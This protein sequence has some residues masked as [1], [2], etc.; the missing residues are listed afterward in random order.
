SCHGVAPPSPGNQSITPLVGSMVMPAGAVSRVHSSAGPSTSLAC[1][2]YWY[3]A[4][5]VAAVTADEVIT[6]A[7]LTPAT[8]TLMVMLSLASPS[9]TRT[10]K[11]SLPAK[12]AFGV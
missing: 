10:T 11:L 6:G 1:T 9:L 3:G 12:F 8:F 4:P 2:L 7:S 5:S